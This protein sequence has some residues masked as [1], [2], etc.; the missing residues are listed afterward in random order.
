MSGAS[1]E[2]ALISMRPPVYEQRWSFMLNHISTD[3]SVLS[4]KD[5]FCFEKLVIKTNLVANM[6]LD[7][8]CGSTLCASPPCNA[9]MEH[10]QRMYERLEPTTRYLHLKGTLQF[11]SACNDFQSAYLHYNS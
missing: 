10:M 1:R 2:V 6:Q 4:A 5:G 8:E 7:H 9:H 11:V 3:Q